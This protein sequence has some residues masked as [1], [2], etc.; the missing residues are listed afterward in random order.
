MH[1]IHDMLYRGYKHSSSLPEMGLGK[2]AKLLEGLKGTYI[3]KKR[4]YDPKMQN[5]VLRE[6]TQKRNNWICFPPSFRSGSWSLAY[7]IVL[8][9]ISTRAR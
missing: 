4:P 7:I 5:C 6:N 8:L 9:K 3:G 2:G 1:V